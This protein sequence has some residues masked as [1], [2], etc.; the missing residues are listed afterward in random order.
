MTAKAKDIVKYILSAML[1]NLV[2]YE[3]ACGQS[4]SIEHD[5]RVKV[6]NDV[7]KGR[8][9]AIYQKFYEYLYNLNRFLRP[10]GDA[11]DKEEAKKT[12]MELEKDEAV[13]MLMRL[14]GK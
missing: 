10:D 5:V 3:W 11:G 8:L 4:W 12:L 2:N 1:T 14:V 6:D 9:R 7:L 13:Q